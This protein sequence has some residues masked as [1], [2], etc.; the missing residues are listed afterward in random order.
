MP[1]AAMKIKSVIVSK[2]FN[3]YDYTVDLCPDL[4]FLHSPN[5]LGKSTLMRMIYAALR[6][7]VEYLRSTPFGRMDVI[8]DDDEDL[9]VQKY[10]GEMLVLMRKSDVDVD[11]TPADMASICDS[12]YIP[13]ERLTVKR[14]DGHLAPTLEVYAQELADRIKYAKEHRELRQHPRD[15]V[16]EMTDGDL[17]FWCKDLKAKLDFVK[18]AGFEPD[19]PSG[20]KFPPSRYDIAKDRAGYEEL[21]CSID[22]YVGRNYTLAESV[23]IFKDIVNEIYLNKRVEVSETGRISVSMNNG[24]ALQLQKL[25][26]GEKQILIMFYALLFHAPQGCIVIIDEP[27]ISLHVC[28]QQKIG[29]YLLN[30][31]RVRDIQMVVATHSPQIVHDKWDMARELR[32]ADARVP[33]VRGHLQRA[34]HGAHRLRRDVPRGRGH[35]RQQ[36]VRQVRRP[37]AG[38]HRHSALQGQRP[39]RGPRDVR[40]E[41]GRQ[42]ARDSGS[43]PGASQRT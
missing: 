21:A 42:D 36:A 15:D 38:Q 34:Q 39:R 23:I 3:E 41:E 9:V 6:G 4:T 13:P 26:S 19:I 2:L 17:E 16:R 40:Q 7:D 27:E 11:L 18:D 29:D 1:K 43:R 8:F 5:G 30:I 12:L 32:P 28:W 10:Q 20:R 35:N 14:G 37:R 33:D 22:D 31:C 24:T 25:S